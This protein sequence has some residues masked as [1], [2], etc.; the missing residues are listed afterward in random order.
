MQ[1]IQTIQYT[2]EERETI[3]RTD[4]LQ[5]YWEIESYQRKVCNKIRK[6]KNIEIILEE[7]TENGT[8]V[9]GVYKLPFKQLSFRNLAELSEKQRKNLAERFNKAKED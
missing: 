2:P 7:T 3:I 4:D 5:D 8:V 9:H 1:T 6:I